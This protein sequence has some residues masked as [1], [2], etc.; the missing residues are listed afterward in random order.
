MTPDYYAATVGEHDEEPEEMS[1]ATQSTARIVEMTSDDY[2]AD[3]SRISRSMKVDFIHSP[4]EFYKRHKERDPAW[5]NDP[6]K[7]M[8]FGTIFHGIALERKKYDQVAK[9]IPE[10]VLNSEGDCRGKPYMLWKAI[11][12]DYKQWLRPKD[13]EEDK[14]TVAAMMESLKSSSAAQDLLQGTPHPI[15]GKSSPHEV[16]IHWDYEGIECRTRL[17]RFNADCIVDLKTARC[18]DL[19][20]INSSLESDNYYLQAADYQMAVEALT[21]ER[22]PFK[23]IFVETVIPFR[24]V[25]VELGDEILRV[26]GEEFRE[27]WIDRGREEMQAAMMRMQRC[28]DLND[29][30][31]HVGDAPIRMDRPTWAAYKW[32]LNESEAA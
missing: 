8:V 6:S 11:T 14:T 10:H 9:V 2:H 1:T 7:A 3:H 21:G 13:T 31:D 22:L 17:D 27:P 12:P 19:Q 26:R 24:T 18:C 20:A 15:I 23:F 29:W 4:W 30:R 5:Q 16:T 28:A 32:Q 25:V